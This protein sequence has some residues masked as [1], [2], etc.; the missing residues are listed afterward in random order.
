MLM[1]TKVEMVFKP[2]DPNGMLLYN[3]Y[4]TVTTGDFL[5]LSLI[6][7]YL[8]FMF[9]LGTGPATIRFVLKFKDANKLFSN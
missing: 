5:S 4:R 7:G 9:D 2:T 8:E 3:G 6:N 1:F